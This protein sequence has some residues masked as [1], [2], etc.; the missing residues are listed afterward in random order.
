MEIFP[1][2]YAFCGFEASACGLKDGKKEALSHKD[3][4]AQRN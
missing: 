2:F 3:T 4:K 1:W